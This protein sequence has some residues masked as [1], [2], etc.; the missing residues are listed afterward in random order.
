[1]R[2]YAPFRS[3][4]NAVM[5]MPSQGAAATSQTSARRRYPQLN[6]T[7]AL[8]A[9]LPFVG[10]ASSVLVYTLTAGTGA[11]TLSGVAAT[12]VYGRVMVAGQGSFV[13]T[14]NNVTFGYARPTWLAVE[15][16][17]TVWTPA[18]D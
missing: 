13:L 4:P 16:A 9:S 2:R 6:G 15:P 10:S 8:V 12:F 3:T 7:L 11:F 18:T 17:P 1:M 5:A 14:G